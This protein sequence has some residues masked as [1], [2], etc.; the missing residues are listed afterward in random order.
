MTEP[1]MTKTNGGS[2]CLFDDSGRF[3]G[4]VAR[5]VERDPVGPGRDTVYLERPDRVTDQPAA[6]A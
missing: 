5:P 1:I 4:T 2:L 3:L 6:A